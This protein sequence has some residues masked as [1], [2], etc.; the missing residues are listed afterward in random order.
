ML[1]AREETR[2]SDGENRSPRARETDRAREAR[3]PSIQ[4]PGL[5]EN[6]CR[7]HTSRGLILEKIGPAYRK[8]G[9][10][11]SGSVGP[12]KKRPRNASQ[13]AKLIVDIA[14][15]EVEDKPDYRDNRA[16]VELGRLV[17]HGTLGAARG[18]PESRQGSL[19]PTP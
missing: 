3:P 8:S 18:R 15:G 14:S 13:L 9:R 7:P 1:R 16:A 19:E 12:H 17:E 11:F 5:V 10:S 6:T 2:A 4:N